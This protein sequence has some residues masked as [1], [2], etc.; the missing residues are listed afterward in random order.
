MSA[1]DNNPEHMIILSNGQFILVEN[2]VLE[3]LT[4]LTD[5]TGDDDSID[6]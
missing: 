1:S 4:G 5:D 2:S 6:D 3:L